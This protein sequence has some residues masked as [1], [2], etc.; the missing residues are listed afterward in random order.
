MRGVIQ[1]RERAKQIPDFSG[2]RWGNITPTDLDMGIDFRNGIFVFGEMKLP[3]AELPQGQRWFLEHLTDAIA[4][5]GRLSVTFIL[6]HDTRPTE[7]IDAAKCLIRELRSH[8][9]WRKPELSICAKDAI[10][11]ILESKGMVF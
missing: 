6:E 3:G 8:R 7:D 4:E 10:D 5:T 11:L 1:N 9:R 2:M